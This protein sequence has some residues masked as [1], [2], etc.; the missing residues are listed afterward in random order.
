MTDKTIS[1]SAFDVG[2]WIMFSV[3]LFNNFGANDFDL[4]DAIIKALMK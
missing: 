4:Y 3:L 1:S 2:D